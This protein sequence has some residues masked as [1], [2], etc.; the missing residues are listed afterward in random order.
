MG[1][2]VC[3]R[4]C[5]STVLLFVRGG[6]PAGGGRTL[7]VSDSCLS[8]YCN[9]SG[10]GHEFSPVDA[11]SSKLRMGGLSGRARMYR[12]Y[13]MKPSLLARP[14]PS[15]DVSVVT[16]NERTRVATSKHLRRHLTSRRI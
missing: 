2:L 12:M 15:V 5:Q 7:G 11:P 9:H 14:H 10:Q 1:A 4:C 8:C 16:I 6:P 13:V 3:G